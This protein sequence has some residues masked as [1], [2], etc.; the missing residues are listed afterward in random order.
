VEVL[1][2]RGDAIRTALLAARPPDVVA[3]LGRGD[4]SE[5]VSN[6]HIDDRTVLAQTNPRD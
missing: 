6:R 4:L 3:I 1:P 2:R 5:A